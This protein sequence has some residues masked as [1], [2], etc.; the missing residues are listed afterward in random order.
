VEV[1]LSGKIRW[2]SRIWKTIQHFMILLA[3]RLFRYSF[4]SV[5]LT[6]RFLCVCLHPGEND[7]W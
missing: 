2:R 3:E 5:P 7:F 4:C 6:S 1:L